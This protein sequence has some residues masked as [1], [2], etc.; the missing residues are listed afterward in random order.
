MVH[1][2]LIDF[3]SDTLVVKKE[4]TDGQENERRPHS[5]ICPHKW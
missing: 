2:C 5:F 1:T 4:V 3:T